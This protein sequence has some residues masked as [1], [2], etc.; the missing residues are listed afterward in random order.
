MWILYFDKVPRYRFGTVKQQIWMALHLFFHL[1]ILGVVE[2]AQQLVQARYIFYSAGVLGVKVWYGCVGSHLDG[3]ALASNLTKA[4]DYFKINE[5]SQGQLALPYVYDQI[6]IIGNTTNIC[7]PANTTDLNNEFYGIPITFAQFFNRA[8][9]AMFQAFDIDIPAEGV[10]THGLNVAVSSWQVVYTYFWSAIILLLICYSITSLLAHKEE[11]HSWRKYVSW[12]IRT[13]VTAI[14][15]SI[16]MMVVGLTNPTF[17][18]EYIASGWL[19][20][21]VVWTFWLICLSD[22]GHKVWRRRRE[23]KQHYDSV[24]TGPAEPLPIQQEEPGFGGPRRRGTN[25]YGYPS[26]N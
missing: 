7:S 23:R 16:V 18:H 6:Y 9:G 26:H 8:I 20:P 12:P 10:T 5:S 19:L 1:A 15:L 14:I 11:K 21:T 22:R 17:M 4:I 13:R 2:G 3:K 25:A 24:A